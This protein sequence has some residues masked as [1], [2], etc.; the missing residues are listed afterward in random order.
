MRNLFATGSPIPSLHIPGLPSGHYQA[1][2]EH[3]ESVASKLGNLDLV[4]TW[5]LPSLHDAFGRSGPCCSC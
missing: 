4:R 5:Y 3:G 1:F 2:E